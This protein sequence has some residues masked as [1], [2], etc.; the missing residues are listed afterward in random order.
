MNKKP[1][2]NVAIDKIFSSSWKAII[3][4]RFK[5]NNAKLTDI[6]LKT[7]PHIPG[8]IISV[9][10]LAVKT[11]A[12]IPPANQ[13]T[14]RFARNSDRVFLWSKDIFIFKSKVT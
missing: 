1:V 2:N 3:Y 9:I 12:T 10:F 4:F 7:N 11:G 5:I 14:P 6:I 13:V 8:I